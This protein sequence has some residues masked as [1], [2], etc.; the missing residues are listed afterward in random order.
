MADKNIEESQQEK[1]GVTI[2]TQGN[3]DI[4]IPQGTKGS[5]RE[6]DGPDDRHIPNQDRS[7]AANQEKAGSNREQGQ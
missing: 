1:Q 3:R 5:N 7:S 2:G 6:K 4:T